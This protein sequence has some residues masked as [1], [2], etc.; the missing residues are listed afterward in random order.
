MSWLVIK[1]CSAREGADWRTDSAVRRDLKNIAANTGKAT[2]GSAGL[3]KRP[4]WLALIDAIQE[5]SIAAL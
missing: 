3:A 5:E 4:A 1:A 2:L